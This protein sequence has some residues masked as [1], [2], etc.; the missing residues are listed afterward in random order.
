LNT[1]FLLLPDFALILLGTGL[2]RWMHLGDHFWGGVEK[3]VYFI[4]FPA[5]LL[6]AM[7]RA[8][9]DFSSAAPVILT[10]AA[11]LI[12]GMLLSFSPRLIASV[13]GETSELNPLVFASLFQC[14]FRFNSYIGLAVAG[15]L[16]G[17]PGIALMGLIL[18]VCVPWVNVTAVW[19]L[20]RHAEAGVFKE[21][22]RNPLI[23]GTLLGLLLNIAGFT[24]PAPAQN[25]LGRLADASIALGLLA[26]GAA[27]RLDRQKQLS[28]YGLA[29]WYLLV[30]LIAM[31]L[32]AIIVGHFL[33][34]SGLNYAIV[35]LFSGLP[36]AS[37][38]F[39]LATRMGG[40][41]N[42][43]AWQISAGTLLSMLTI[44]ALAVYLTE[45]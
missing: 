44:P 16:F 26:V 45:I 4:F 42:S 14:G 12:T 13:R 23:W 35:V 28:S 19:M 37:S 6:H 33:G 31:P 1:A 36:T 34:L 25:F 18:G 2:R 38:A 3:L 21:L 8:H 43:V 20:A 24:A 27:L 17:T 9:L 41:G 29:T 22:L 10:A 7:L 30:K 15:M 32:T 5:L 11:S 40:D 39:I